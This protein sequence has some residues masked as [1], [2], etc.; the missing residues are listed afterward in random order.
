MPKV[1]SRESFDQFNRAYLAQLKSWNLE[2]SGANP[3]ARTNMVPV[4]G[5]MAEPMIAGFF[6]TAPMAA[7]PNWLLS[8]VPE[9]TD[10]KGQIAV[11][12]P[13]DTSTAGLRIKAEAIFNVI[14]E[15]LREL[16]ASW[17]QATAVNIYTIYDLHALLED[18]ILPTIGDAAYAGLTTH[19]GRPPITGLDLEIDAWASTRQEIVTTV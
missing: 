19:H 5:P 13:G 6:H 3:V 18:L 11:A 4:I 8:G 17:G 2:V 1:L 14:A 10:L 12:A 7:T 9:F 16:E 15:R